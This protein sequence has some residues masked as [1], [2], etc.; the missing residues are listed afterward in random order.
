MPITMYFAPTYVFTY[1]S[2]PPVPAIPQVNRRG[3][4]GGQP[5]TT[6]AAPMA[7][8]WNY[9]TTGAPPAAVTLPPGPAR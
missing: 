3:W 6:T 1:Q 2:G 9:A 7:G 4:W 5:A 8:S